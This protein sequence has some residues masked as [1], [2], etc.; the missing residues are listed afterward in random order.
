MSV[1]R[2]MKPRKADYFQT[3]VSQY[4]PQPFELMQRAVDNV[5]A[6]YDEI[7]AQKK[8]MDQA[9]I[10]MGSHTGVD[11][12]DIKK[13]STYYTDLANEALD[14]PDLVEA[15]KRIYEIGKQMGQDVQIRQLLASG[16]A[17]KQYQT[18]KK[19]AYGKELGKG[20][21]SAARD[22]V[23]SDFHKTHQQR[24]TLRS[25]GRIFTQDFK[26]SADVAQ[27][28]MDF[29][30]EMKPDTVIEY[31]NFHR[32]TV[33]E[34]HQFINVN[35]E[36]LDANDVQTATAAY[37]MDKDD[38]RDEL[39]M[40]ALHKTSLATGFTPTELIENNF[41]NTK[42]GRA[43]VLAEALDIAINPAA[44]YSY[45]D[46]TGSA[47][48]IKGTGFAAGE[49]TKKN[50]FVEVKANLQ[51]EKTGASTTRS[52]SDLATEKASTRAQITQEAKKL[53]ASGYVKKEDLDKFFEG[54]P[55]KNTQYLRHLYTQLNTLE[56][57]EQE[58]LNN[59]EVRN[60]TLDKTYLKPVKNELEALGVS[61]LDYLRLS[62]GEGFK[63]GNIHYEMAKRGIGGTP[64][65][66]VPALYETL[67]GEK[68][69]VDK[70]E[71]VPPDK[72]IEYAKNGNA[73]HQEAYNKYKTLTNNMITYDKKNDAYVD[74]INDYL[75]RTGEGW[76]KTTRGSNMLH[77]YNTD[78]SLDNKAS[79]GATKAIK[80]HFKNPA[81]LAGYKALVYTGEG[82]GD[83]VGAIETENLL[84]V[85]NEQKEKL[86]DAFEVSD[87][88][89][90]ETIGADGN[91]FVEVA[92]GEVM[93][94]VPITRGQFGE[95]FKK[96]NTLDR[97]VN[98][99]LLT[100][101]KSGISEYPIYYKDE[102][103][104]Q[105]KVAYLRLPRDSKSLLQQGS[106][107]FAN[108]DM[109]NMKVYDYNS[110]TGKTTSS[111]KILNGDETRFLLK[112]IEAK[113]G[114]K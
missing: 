15:E 36:F 75:N 98:S 65:R 84:D 113:T 78:G 69:T 67:Y 49:D 85:I 26:T 28:A 96:I 107:T 101:M 61:E 104:N 34:I 93:A 18:R 33:D 23:H 91:Y 83:E 51:A 17:E 32:G 40:R 100:T 103:T 24:G 44:A 87:F 60:S 6:Q 42:E 57:R 48:N 64:Y 95:Q 102:N 72:V 92:I 81:N 47:S 52:M 35:K 71:Q 70:M 7:E 19:E 66:L 37:L 41:F 10:N 12:E 38:T 5:Q 114:L 3:Y 58:A 11:T 97:R 2:F 90:S 77:V 74:K 111:A 76:A 82:E 25:D 89:Y 21:I 108:N 53:G 39:E 30:K 79:V 94:H 9:L 62:S 20:G 50:P 1:N 106:N 54:K 55:V 56:M 43:T 22:Y 68:Y 29:G 80:E 45:T 73:Q 88:R 4:V 99:F 109:M 27:E 105:E 86:G 112:A 59:A 63:E 16:A 110:K 46:R 13:I 31:L 14:G 8:N